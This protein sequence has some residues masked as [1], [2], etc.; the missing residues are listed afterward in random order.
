MKFHAFFP[1][2][3]ALLFYAN[4]PA[5]PTLQCGTPSISDEEFEQLPW[6][7]DF[8]KVERGIDT[9]QELLAQNVS[10]RNGAACPYQTTGWQGVIPVPVHLWI[11]RENE[12][13]DIPEDEFYQQMFDF[14]NFV[15]QNSGL[16]IHFYISCQTVITNPAFVDIDNNDEL[17]DMME[18]NSDGSSLNLHVVRSGQTSGGFQW[19]GI[20]NTSH[21][22]FAVVRGAVNGFST[23]LAHEIGHYF[24]LQH[25]HRRTNQDPAFQNADGLN[26]PCRR[27]AVS[28]VPI[29]DPGCLFPPWLKISDCSRTG[30]GFCDT[31]ADATGNGCFSY[32]GTFVDFTGT[33]FTPDITN[34]MSYYPCTETF[35]NQQVQAMLHNI[36]SR[37][38]QFFSPWFQ[39]YYG[40]IVRG[41]Q[42]EPDNVVLQARWIT[43][44][45]TQIHSL[46]SGCDKEEDWYRLQPN[47]AIGNYVVT[48][49][50]ITNCD[51]PVDE[52]KVLYR[53]ANDEIVDFP[54]ATITQSGST[55]TATISCADVN[56]N[57]IFV[58]VENNGT[59]PRG[60]YQISVTSSTGQPVLNSSTNSLCNGLTLEVTGLPSNATVTWTSSS[61]ITLTNTSGATNSIASFVQGGSNYWVRAT[62]S[63][64][65]CTMQLVKTFTYDANLGIPDFYIVEEIPACYYYGTGHYSISNDDPNVNYSW[66]CQGAPCFDISTIGNG[67]LALVEA[68]APGLMTLT[69]VATDGCG[70]NLTKSRSFNVG[71]CDKQQMSITPNP[72]SSVINVMIEDEFTIE[73][74][75]TTYIVS[76]FSELKFQGDFSTKTFQINVATLPNGVYYIHA[77]R[78]NQILSATFIVNHE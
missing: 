53:D 45:T 61:N 74:I 54:G 73:G 26:T 40:L 63:L 69:V 15:F 70:N 6:Y 24:T 7:G 57:S 67:S 34:V 36:L 76:Q 14:N 27:E 50:K 22:D 62:I 2:A 28:R 48:V 59:A 72:T 11:Y 49:S 46:H 35:S 78:E 20:Y 47:T 60:Y 21:D 33:A 29:I 30:D 64:N 17:D 41:D 52:L 3:F 4:L 16:P 44:G 8:S 10:E 13:D 38:G 5:Q 66:T 43:G 23:T 39:N 31:P 77:I 37:S 71:R 51:F 42:F 68:D 18:E 56:A 1:A 25:T 19:G 55:I 12:D 75:Y 9:L 65:G 32:F 58:Q